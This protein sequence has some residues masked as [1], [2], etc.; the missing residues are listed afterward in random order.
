MAD[1]SLRPE[2]NKNPFYR[3]VFILVEKADP[4][5]LF[6]DFS[7]KLKC[8]ITSMPNQETQKYYIKFKCQN[9]GFEDSPRKFNLS[10]R[11]W[12]NVSCPQ[13]HK[14]KLVITVNNVEVPELSKIPQIGLYFLVNRSRQNPEADIYKI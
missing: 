5:G 14:S 13:C 6:L 12:K 8:K 7:L 9:C 4:D 3:G 11:I 1:K 2:Y 10:G